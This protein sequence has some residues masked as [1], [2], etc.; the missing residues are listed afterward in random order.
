[1]L[2]ACC[3]PEDARAAVQAGAEAVIVSN[4]GGVSS[5]ARSAPAQPCRALLRQLEAKPISSSMAAPGAGPTSKSAGARRPRL[6][7]RSPMGLA[8]AGEEGV[9][10]AIDILAAELDEAMALVGVPDLAS[11]TADFVREWVH[12]TVGQQQ[13]PH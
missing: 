5:T 1:V 8:A 2:R 3:T 12:L 10:H 7:D 13:H 9:L 4:H 11:I 6:H